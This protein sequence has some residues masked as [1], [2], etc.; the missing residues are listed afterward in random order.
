MSLSVTKSKSGLCGQGGFVR[1]LLFSKTRRFS[2][3]YLSEY[4][5]ELAINLSPEPTNL[6]Y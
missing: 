3:I 5:K 6:N 2:R 1:F 4:F